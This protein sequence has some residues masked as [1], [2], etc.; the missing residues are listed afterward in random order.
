MLFCSTI[1]GRKSVMYESFT[2]SQ[3]AVTN[4]KL[5]TCFF[6]RSRNRMYYVD[7]PDFHVLSL[8]TVTFLKV[9]LTFL[10]VFGFGII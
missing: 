3:V 7:G 4:D 10:K 6:C 1:S 9:F 5:L 8:V 2:N